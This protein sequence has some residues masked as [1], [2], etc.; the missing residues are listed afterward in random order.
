MPEPKRGATP[1][2]EPDIPEEAGHRPW[3]GPNGEVH[4][5]GSGA[6]GGNPGEDYDQDPEGGDGSVDLESE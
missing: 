2:A 4:G 6:G 3:F 1:V 5:S